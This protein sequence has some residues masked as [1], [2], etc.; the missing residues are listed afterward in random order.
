MRA[1]VFVSFDHDP[2]RCIRNTKIEDLASS[3]QSIE[4]MHDLLNTGS[5]IPPMHIQQINIIRTHLL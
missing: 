1:S 2:S 4:T 3:D 5:E